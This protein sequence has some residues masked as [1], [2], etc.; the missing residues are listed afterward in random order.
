M[1]KPIILIVVG[2]VVCIAYSIGC[3]KLLVDHFNIISESA[4]E[5]LCPMSLVSGLLVGLLFK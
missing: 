1:V 3:E 4:A 2:I 5:V